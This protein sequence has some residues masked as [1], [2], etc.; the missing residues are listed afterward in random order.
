M[1]IMAECRARGAA[2]G[3]SASVILKELRKRRFPANYVDNIGNTLDDVKNERR[4]EMAMVMRWHDLKRYNA[5]DNANITVTKRG[6]LDPLDFNSEVF[7]FR[8]A[9]NAPTYALPIIQREVDFLG[10]E[11]NEYGGIT[12]Q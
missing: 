6:R 10:W 8:L 3:E 4:R 5:L 2:D 7:T 11:Q 12:R 1:L 9:P